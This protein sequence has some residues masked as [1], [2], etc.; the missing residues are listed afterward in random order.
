M[1]NHCDIHL[2]IAIGYADRKGEPILNSHQLLVLDYFRSRDGINRLGLDSW[3][4]SRKEFD[5]DIQLIWL[6]KGLVILERELK[7]GRGSVACSI[8]VY[9]MLQE[10]NL[11]EDFQIADFGLRN[12]DNPWAPFGYPYYGKRTITDY[13]ADR[14]ATLNFSAIKSDRHEK[15]LKRVEGRKEKRTAA[16]AELRKLSK[17]QRGASRIG[18]LE[19]YRNSTTTEKLETIANENV[20]PPEYFPAEWIKL[21]KEE[22]AKLPIDLIKK[23]SDKLSAKTKGEWKRFRRELEKYDDG[24]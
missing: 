23:L 20:F 9:K 13:L 1:L 18:L 8:W 2:I 10:A 7:W 5:D 21:P 14:N 12:C 3:R 15:V 16:I 4:N 24:I 11:D 19:K 22:I 17:E 6:F